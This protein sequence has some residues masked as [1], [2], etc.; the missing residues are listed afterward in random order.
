MMSLQ[1]IPGDRGV[2]ALIVRVK[3]NIDVE[4]R[5]RTFHIARGVYVYVGSARASGGLR[6]R[7]KRYIT[8]A[9]NPHWHIDYLLA[10]P[11]SELLY[12]CFHISEEDLESL[13]ARKLIGSCLPVVG[14]GSSDKRRD[15]SHLFRCGESQDEAIHAVRT[16][17]PR[18]TCVAL[19]E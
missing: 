9:R 13:L 12:V 5:S 17:L 11:Y 14:F 2:Y 6:G 1:E 16:L 4:T 15:V 10:S 7:L 8:G 3:K 19:K 18:L